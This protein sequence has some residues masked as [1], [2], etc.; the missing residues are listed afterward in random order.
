MALRKLLRNDVSSCTLFFYL[1]AH[2][3]D[4]LPLAEEI[5]LVFSQCPLAVIMID[6]FQVPSDPGYEYDDYGAGRALIPSYIASPITTYNL[7]AFYPATPS[8]EESGL[9]RG[10]IVLARQAAAAQALSSLALLR[11]AA[12]AEL[13]SPEH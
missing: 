13:A 3:N 5:D 11:P 10:C 1:D 2:W 4:D 12:E 8:A 6:D 9:R 7:Q